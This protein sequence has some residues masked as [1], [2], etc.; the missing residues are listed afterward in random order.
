M[1]KIIVCLV[2][3]LLCVSMV[4]PAFATEFTPSVENKP[5]PSLVPVLDGDG[6]PHPGAVLDKDGNVVSY[7][8][9]DCLVITSVADADI[10]VDIPKSAKDLLLWLY[11]QLMRGNMSMPYHL[12]NPL[13]DSD[14]MVIRDMFD[15]TFLCGD[16][17]E[18][19]EAVGVVLVLTFDLGVKPNQDVSVMTY[20]EEDGGWADIHDIVNNGDGT[21]TCTFEHLCPVAFSVAVADGP[22]QTGD[23]DT[24]SI[25][26]LVA[27]ASLLAIAVLT[28]IYYRSTKKA[29]R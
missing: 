16:H 18:A 10:S 29:A 11:Q 8:D 15:V 27:L 3:A 13:Y 21:V 12:H 1:K 17:P 6:N 22:S 7:L 19:L 5:A 4:S 24:V 2:V 20:K 9:E 14:D 25:W 26:G 23:T 28:Y